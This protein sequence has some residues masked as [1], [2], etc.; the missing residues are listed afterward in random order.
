MAHNPITLDL[1][2][3]LDAIDQ[4]GS[5]AAA[6][7]ALHKVPSALTYTVQK[8]EQ[9]L[10]LKLFDRS[11]HRARLT[12][13]GK[14]IL[15]GGRLIL[16]DIDSL[17]ASAKQIASGWE[18]TLTISVD[19][20][21]ESERLFPLVK[22]FN[23]Q[24][25]FVKVRLQHDS[26]TG[27]WEKLLNRQ[28]DLIISTKRLAPAVEGYTTKP[29]GSIRQEFAV[30]YNHPLAQRQHIEE[31][32]IEPYNVIVVPDTSHTISTQTFGWTKQNK[33][34]VVASMSAKIHAQVEGLGVGYLPSHRIQEHIQQQRLTVLTLPSTEDDA[35]CAWR[36]GADGPALT[37]FTERIDGHL[38]GL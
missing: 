16:R 1:L 6:A 29:I 33:S 7:D 20:L 22:T 31:K 14:L 28:A 3:T 38:L 36:S 12:E 5:F 19:T 25:P 8:I 2:R 30:S 23:D 21:F 35:L 24:H 27:T 15:D 37:W 32:D 18:T 11:G 10:E 9:D 17:A 26:L 34:I 13:A 4:K